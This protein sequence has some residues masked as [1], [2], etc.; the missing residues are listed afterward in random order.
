MLVAHKHPTGTTAHQVGRGVG[1]VVGILALELLAYGLNRFLA[2]PA[3]R[4]AIKVRL[5]RKLL[6]KADAL[7]LDRLAHRILQNEN[8]A[9]EILQLEDT[10]EEREKDLEAAK[11]AGTHSRDEM[12]A[13]TEALR[14]QAKERTKNIVK[15]RDDLL[16]QLRRLM[17]AKPPAIHKP[18]PVDPPGDT[19]LRDHEPTESFSDEVLLE[20]FQ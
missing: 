1:A 14:K 10:I 4:R 5:R 19:N 8:E 13:E 3:F 11:V 15:A 6:P 16:I 12:A 9:S 7:T 20:D 17:G 2:E 18:R